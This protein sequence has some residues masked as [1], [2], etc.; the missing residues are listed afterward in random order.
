MNRRNKLSYSKDLS[1]LF[2]LCLLSSTL[3]ISCAQKGSDTNSESAVP[4]N[5]EFDLVILNGRVMDP[6]TNFDEVRN[7]GVLDGK[8]ALITEESISGKET[9]DATGHVVAPG[10]IDFHNHIANTPFG[11]R[12]ALRDGVTTPLEMEAGGYPIDMWYNALEG[13]SQTNY[14]ATVST[15]GIRE[16]IANPNYDTNSGSFVMDITNADTESNPDLQFATLLATPE[17]LDQMRQM[18]IEGVEQGGLG[19]GGL[20]GYMTNGT[21]SQETIMWQQ[22]A[23]KYGLAVYIHGRFSS[24]M[25]PTSGILGTQEFLASVGIYGGGLYVHHVHQQTLDLT[26]AVLDLIEDAQ[27]KGMKVLAEI[28]PYYQGQTIVSADYLKPETYQKNMGRDYG[29]LFEISNMQPL[30]KERYE[31]M[32]R[33]SPQDQVIFG[34]ISEEGMLSALADPRTVIGSDA[35]PLVIPASGKSAMDFDL[36]F[37]SVS[38]HPRAAGTH[39]KVLK[40]VR[41]KKLM[42]LMLAISKMTIM[43]AKWLEE[44]GVKSMSQKGRLQIGKDADITIFNSENVTDNSTFKQGALPSTGIPYVVVNGTIVVKDSKVLEGVYPGKAIKNDL[45]KQ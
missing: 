7:V 5:T 45:V 10:F 37:E 28:Y 38:G 41:E 15:A 11:Q 4:S 35:P 12:I 31:E 13:R 30:T 18:F 2:F 32:I 42:P 34:G 26:P 19:I 33:T 24:Q 14:G 9:I 43:Q 29:D 3:L 21:K 39:A 6:E 27:N 17:Q 23:G 40:L 36:P 25:P 44:N 1:R 16:K 22:V 20:P 8:I